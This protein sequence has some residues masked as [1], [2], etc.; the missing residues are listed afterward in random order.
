[1]T[2]T[3]QDE[4]TQRTQVLS[5]YLEGETNVSHLARKYGVSRK[6]LYKW[7]RRHRAGG[8]SALQDQSRAPHQSP[9]TLAPE[10]VEAIIALKKRWP[11]WGAPKIRQKLLEQQP[12]I[13]GPAESTVSAVLH[14]HGL[15]RAK[16]RRRRATILA[17]T[18]PAMAGAN[19]TWCVDFKGW[20]R[21]GDG[22]VCTPLTITDGHSRYLLRCQGLGGSTAG[23]V[24]KPLFI[25]AFR[26]YGLPRSILSD[27]GPPF[28]S[29][30]LGG[31]SELCTWWMRLGIEIRR[32]EPGHPEQNGRHERMH[33]TLKE[34]TA[35]PPKQNLR[36]QQRAFDEFRKQY[37]EE[38]PHEGLGQEVPA[39][40]YGNSE[41]VY[42][43]RMPAARAYPDDWERRKVRTAGQIKWQGRNVRINQALRGETIGFEPRGKGRWGV[44]FEWLEL[45]VFDE[46]KRKIKASGKKRR[47]MKKQVSK[48]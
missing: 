23:L 45:G 2:W 28:A 19:D 18:Q 6:T 48:E 10:V 37:N 39:K 5:E 34:A 42:P 22:N 32:I 38:R 27:N 41:R 21:T 12:G 46:A 4:V 26:E 20:F 47:R 30:G 36:A 9:Q 25:E 13:K 40:H 8:W 11:L 24:I 14:R 33:R 44:W 43:T 17:G 31:M 7:L 35:S 29:T 3:R 16:K 15:V 1:M